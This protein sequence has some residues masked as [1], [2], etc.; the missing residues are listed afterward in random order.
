MRVDLFYA[1]ARFT[2][3][4][5]IDKLGCVF[6]MIPAAVLIWLYGCFFVWRNLITPTTSASDRYDRLLAKS[7]ALR[8][9]VETL[10][11]LN[12]FNAWFLFKVLLIAFTAL[13][14]LTALSFLWRS[15]LE[16]RE[17]AVSAGRYLDR[18]PPADAAAA[19]AAHAT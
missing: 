3:K 9:N 18:E 15:L 17:D 13:M 19:F 14:S 6:F 12:G 4:K 2:R 7:A 1:P 8:W 11:L 5:W 10:F 16:W